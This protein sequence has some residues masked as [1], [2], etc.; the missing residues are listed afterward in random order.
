MTLLICEVTQLEVSTD[1]NIMFMIASHHLS[2]FTTRLKTL[3]CL[4]VSR[5][6]KNISRAVGAPAEIQA[7]HL[8][9]S[10]EHYCHIN[11]HSYSLLNIPHSSV[12]P[13]PLCCCSHFTITLHIFKNM[14]FTLYHCLQLMPTWTAASHWPPAAAS[15]AVTKVQL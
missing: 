4:A 2:C 12:S 14:M 6:I 10:A 11:L 13:S 5:D 9:A 15:L 3:I 1:N 8:S 7:E